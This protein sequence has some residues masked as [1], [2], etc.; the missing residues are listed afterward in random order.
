ME[1]QGWLGLTRETLFEIL[2]IR[3]T[4]FLDP[5]VS[6]D[7]QVKISSETCFLQ[8]NSVARLASYG[9]RRQKFHSK[10]C[11]SRVSQANFVTR[12]ASYESC[13]QKFRRET[14]ENQY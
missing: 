14:R 4:R 2:A 10:A 13:K 9:S 8:T 12:L 3:E 1:E 11:F 7:S 6:R 5:K